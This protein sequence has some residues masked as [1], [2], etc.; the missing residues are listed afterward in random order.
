MV[1]LHYALYAQDNLK[2]SVNFKNEPVGNVLR[3]IEK[4]TGYNFVYNAEHIKGLRPVTLTATDL[5]LKNFLVFI[6]GSTLSYEIEGTNIIVK[7]NNRKHSDKVISG[8]VKDENGEIM[9]GVTLYLKNNPS[10]GTVSDKDG[11]FNI[12]VPDNINLSAGELFLQVSY[13]GYSK[14][15][16]KITEYGHPF[17]ITIEP[18]IFA[19]KEVVISTGYQTLKKGETLG[20][21]SVI[22][23]DLTN[24]SVSTDILS[25][26]DN[27]SN[28]LMF[29]KRFIGSPTLIIRGQS[30]IQ[31]NDSPLIILDNF[32][33]EGDINNIN[34]N[35]VE[36]ITILKDAAAASIWGVRAGNGVIV[37][38]SKKGKF[39]QPASIQFN[40]NLTVGQKPNLYYNKNFLNSS[41]FI[42]VEKY[43]FE[44]NFYA[45]SESDPSQVLTPVVQLL[46]AE[47]DGKISSS[48]AEILIN[49]YSDQDVRKDFNKYLYRESINQQYSISFKGGSS[50]VNYYLNAGLDK[51]NDNLIRNGLTR[52]TINTMLTYR[53]IP[54]L[55]FSSNIV[56][57]KTKQSSN[58]SGAAYISPGGI[59]GIYPYARLADDNGNPLSI[60]KDYNSEFI[61]QAQSN[62]LLD[63]SYVPLEDLNN[64]DYTTQTG[65][66]RI[67]SAAKYK[68]S[69]WLEIEG[70]YQYQNQ[71]QNIR[72]LQNENLY[73]TRNLINQYAYKDVNNIVQFP[74]PK[75]SILDN[76]YSSIIS[77]DTRL[78]LNFN[79]EWKN[80]HRLT[81]LLGA[82]IRQ[83][84]INRSSNRIYGYNNE[85]LT[86]TS[87][88][89]TTSFTLNP[90]GSSARI[91]G[92]IS[93]N[94]TIDR[95]LSYYWNGHYSYMNRYIFSASTRKD[96]SNLFGVDA[97]QK[98]IPLWSV[99][100]GWQF[101]S[102]KFYSLTNWL[103]I[104]KFRFTYGYSGNVNK[105][106]TAY[107]TGMYMNSSVTG[108]PYVQILTP[109]NPNLRWEKVKMIN[110]GIDF[111]SRNNFL[112]GSIEYYLKRGI[113]LIGKAPIDPTIG[114]SVGGR[115]EF[116]GNNSSMKGKGLDV[117]LNFNKTIGQFIWTAQF[118][119]SH[120][121]DKI[122]RYDYESSYISSYLSST[123][124]PVPG[125]PKYS[126]YSLKWAG[127]D[128]ENGDSR[129]Y[130]NG[131]ITK[132][133]S[134]ILSKLTLKDLKYNGSALP[135]HFGTFRN[136]FSFGK[137]SLGFNISYKFGYYFRKSS[138]SY[139]SLFNTWIGNE[140][141]SIRWKNPGDEK[142]TN[143]PSMP[144]PGT[145][146]T[147]DD[148][149]TFSD[150]LVQKGDHIRFQDINISYD[151]NRSTYKWLPCRKISLYGYINNIGIIWRANKDKLDPDY[152]FQSYPASRTYS[153]GINITF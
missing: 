136:N 7:P 11:S 49:K 149:Y 112:S 109:P 26:L 4:Q 121:V 133:Y 127:L 71:N 114:F 63:W 107:A 36:D 68:V 73:Y 116:V 125:N 33:Y 45:S 66:I 95:N 64:Q 89:Y 5:D 99:G 123:P 83:T 65:D 57:S 50:T 117:Q 80:I 24:R 106:L 46:M 138:L 91:P 55:E 10:I 113:D 77:Q 70:R 137:L 6:F 132:D 126:I 41:D 62:G 59:K 17:I 84:N 122:T 44:N 92:G 2:V 60:V 105:S 151:M 16:I 40:T 140:D 30:T 75:G 87:V 119:Y 32:P 110:F 20:S 135:T 103:P 97:N 82:E 18:E 12:K 1:L 78:S 76:T 146:S 147:R 145:S 31:S 79:K 88:D 90:S 54:S 58:N 15:S 53:P 27:I 61:S 102:E 13:I 128:P 72:N 148:I 28:G 9:P 118:L 152:V 85:L 74:I 139:S 153:L 22:N 37:I 100:L 141:Y 35:D 124:I 150:I 42:D 142:I 14:K 29:D 129:I 43:L 101:S 48:E 38:T 56:Y 130:I 39:E 86:Y 69:S 98:G 111:E 104:L 3:E 52:T 25:R 8:I 115:N 93:L 144:A 134:T 81:M 34:P 51:N 96:E 23:N 67:N 19:L 94:E 47:R 120:S 143:V 131:E 108:L 21:Y